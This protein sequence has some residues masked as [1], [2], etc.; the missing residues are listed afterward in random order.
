MKLTK[1]HFGYLFL[2]IALI[3]A[4]VN[5]W[6]DAQDL[7]AKIYGASMPFLMGAGLAYIINIVMSGYE[8][9]MRVL[10]KRDIPGH[11]AISMILSYLTFVIVIFLIFYIVL[12]DLVSSLR[13]LT[14][15]DFNGIAKALDELQENEAVQKFQKNFGIDLDQT[16][17]RWLTNYNR[18]ISST[19]VGILSGLLS[20]VTNLAS[21]LVSVFISLVFSIYVLAGK[22]KLGRQGN[23]LVH[24]Y[25]P[26]IEERF[27]YVRRTAHES[28]HGFFRGQTIEA[29]ILGS[30]C[31]S[32]MMLFKLPFAATIG[33]LVG[34]TALIP[35]VGAYI[36]VSIGAVLIMTQSVPQAIFFIVYVIILQQFEGNL[37]YP[38]VVG[39]SIGLP[40]IW[41]IVSISIGVALGGIFGMLIA[42]PSAATIY[43]LIRAHVHKKHLEEEKRPIIE[44]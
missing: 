16:V 39:G 14:K 19:L 1:R 3:Y 30:L 27:H 37:I 22:E 38:R 18:Q 11:R 42:V 4:T 36:G 26:A 41:V 43:K 8:D 17:N 12:P 24:A 10:F 6:S 21:G 35:V 5:Y 13:N 15:I 40:G 32:G 31:A 2:V 23:M 25:L 33:I 20:S 28:F 44:A 34:F 9:G 29:V 7:L